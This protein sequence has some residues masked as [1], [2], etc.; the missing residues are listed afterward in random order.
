MQNLIH[1]WEKECLSVKCRIQYIGGRKRVWGFNAEFNKLVGE[2][3]FGV[4]RLQCVF[5]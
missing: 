2:R 1:W 5:T 4:N 3:R